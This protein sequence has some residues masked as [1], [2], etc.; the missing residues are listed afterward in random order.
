MREITG[1]ERLPTKDNDQM[2][3]PKPPIPANVDLT[4][5]GNY[6]CE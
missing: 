3:T 2:T 1:K 5:G 6:E 4:K